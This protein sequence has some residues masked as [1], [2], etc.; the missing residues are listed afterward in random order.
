VA[1]HPAEQ[2]LD[3]VPEFEPDY[4]L[5]IVLD[6]FADHVSAGVRA[7]A[8]RQEWFDAVEELAASGDPRVQNAVIV[9]FLEA[10]MWGELGAVAR[11]GPATRAL[12][13]EADPRMIDPVMLRE[14]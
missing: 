3:A 14:A 9:S 13:R 5:T 6:E 1:R 2:L 12:I 11:M 4:P 7:G 10:A 8:P